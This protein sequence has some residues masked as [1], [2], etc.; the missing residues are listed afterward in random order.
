MSKRYICT[1]IDIKRLSEKVAYKC[2]SR[3]HS[4]MILL[5]WLVKNKSCKIIKEQLNTG[6]KYVHKKCHIKVMYFWNHVLMYVYI[7]L[8]NFG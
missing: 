6:M 1:N 5:I 8:N 3:I 4:F 7:Y 2:S